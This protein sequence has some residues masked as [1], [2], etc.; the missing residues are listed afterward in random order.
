MSDQDPRPARPGW[1]DKEFQKAL[2][3]GNVVLYNIYVNFE[4]KSQRVAKYYIKKSRSVVCCI[5]PEDV[6]P[7]V[8]LSPHECILV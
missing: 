3:N 4:R 1:D 2:Q 6:F 8:V 7:G 5:V